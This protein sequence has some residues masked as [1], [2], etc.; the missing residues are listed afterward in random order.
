MKIF[1]VR[2]DFRIGLREADWAYPVCA[3]SQDKDMIA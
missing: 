1:Q 3:L 2:L